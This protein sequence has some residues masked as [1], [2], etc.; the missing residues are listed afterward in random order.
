VARL[1]S[2]KRTLAAAGARKTTSSEF[3]RSL[4]IT[5]IIRSNIS[6]R[7]LQELLVL[8]NGLVH[9]YFLSILQ[10][11]TFSRTGKYRRDRQT[12]VLN[13]YKDIRADDPATYTY[14]CQCGEYDGTDEEDEIFGT[15][16]P[17]FLEVS[18]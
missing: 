9:P 7:L 15:L 12:V 2:V 6:K 3:C 1:R 10:Y 4:R 8:R 11:L 14:D 5:S 16:S 13:H 17:L 18:V